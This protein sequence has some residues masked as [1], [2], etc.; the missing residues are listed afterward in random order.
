MYNKKKRTEQTI[1]YI[2]VII[3]LIIVTFTITII[4]QHNVSDNVNEKSRTVTSDK[5]E[6]FE[7]DSLHIDVL[8]NQENFDTV[9]IESVLAPYGKS[10]EVK[11]D[12]R[13]T[14]EN[15][16]R[17]LNSLTKPSTMQILDILF[18]KDLKDNHS[19]VSKIEIESSAREKSN[20]VEDDPIK[21]D[22][23]KTIPL[24]LKISP[25]MISYSTTTLDEKKVKHD[26]LMVSTS[27]EYLL[28]FNLY[29]Y[30]DKLG[31]SYFKIVISPNSTTNLLGRFDKDMI[32]FY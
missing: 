3:L 30:Q 6:D 12:I 23:V 31:N 5:L 1:K 20:V 28:D 29:T 14:D 21:D 22:I 16:N 8:L 2:T 9:N 11:S 27:A 17:V 24:K 32:F 13:T 15:I 10:Q 7:D 25:P 4:F 18:N 19:I 26:N